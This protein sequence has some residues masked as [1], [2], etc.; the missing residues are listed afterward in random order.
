[1]PAIDSELPLLSIPSFSTDRFPYNQ[2][3]GI[4]D[5]VTI[6][7]CKEPSRMDANGVKKLTSSHPKGQGGYPTVLTV[8]L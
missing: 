7:S 6:H 4:D 8:I 2:R 5:N 1:M 3:D